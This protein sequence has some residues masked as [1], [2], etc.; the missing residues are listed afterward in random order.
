MPPIPKDKTTELCYQTNM[1]VGHMFSAVQVLKLLLLFYT[2]LLPFVRLK[3]THLMI[4]M[5]SIGLTT[6]C[7][8]GKFFF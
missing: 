6:K 8:E 4:V 3:Q 2:G 7:R 1:E 5:P